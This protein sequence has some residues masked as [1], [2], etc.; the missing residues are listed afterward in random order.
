MTSQ[1]L[2]DIEIDEEHKI[3]NDPYSFENITDKLEEFI[4]KASSASASMRSKLMQRMVF[5]IL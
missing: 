5:L 2:F 4:K 1:G 3:I